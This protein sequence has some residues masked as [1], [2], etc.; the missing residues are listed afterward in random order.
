MPRTAARS[1][2]VPNQTELNRTEPQPNRADEAPMAPPPRDRGAGGVTNGI[3]A[4]KRGLSQQAVLGFCVSRACQ[5]LL[6]PQPPL[7]KGG[8]NSESACCSFAGRRLEI[9]EG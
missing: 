7:A 6:P 5:C 9:S 3:F 1:K 2:A 4:F 8:E